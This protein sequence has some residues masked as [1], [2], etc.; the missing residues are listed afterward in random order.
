MFSGEGEMD[1]KKKFSDKITKIIGELP[2]FPYEIDR[3]LATAVRPSEDNSKILLMI[4]SHPEL[5]EELLK[6][7]RVY[8]K[9]VGEIKTIEDAAE[10]IGI[11][12]LVQLIGIS[13]ARN[14]IEE[15]FSALKHLNEYLD[16][17]EDISLGCRALAEVMEMAKEQC[18]MYSV[19]GLIHDIGRL[20]ILAAMNKTSAHVLGTLWDK[21]TSVINE[22]KAN[23][24]LNHCEIGLQICKKWNF[25]PVIQEG[26]LRHHTPLVDSDFSFPGGVIF[27]SHFLSA[28]DPSGDIISTLLPPEILGR[29]NVSTAQFDKARNIYR[30]RAGANSD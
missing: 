5:A 20:A 11:Q 27:V 28:S 10:I 8:Y 22:E 1:K 24:G 21:M 4:E 12:P 15:E 3:L 9:T 6:V 14:A 2:L 7:A 17:S 13:Y 16:H 30:K 18:E 25:S 26:V 19:A 29:L 23:L